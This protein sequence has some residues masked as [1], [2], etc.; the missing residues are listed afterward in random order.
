MSV[1]TVEAILE[2]MGRYPDLAKWDFVHALDVR[3]L[4]DSMHQ[5]YLLRWREGNAIDEINGQFDIEHT[6]LSYNLNDVRLAA[7]QL[8]LSIVSEARP[9]ARVTLQVE[10]TVV[11]LQRL[12]GIRQLAHYDALD[13]LRLRSDHTLVAADGRLQLD[14]PS[15][16]DFFI[17]GMGSS[18]DGTL[19]GVFF[20]RHFAQLSDAQR[21]FLLAGIRPLPDK[22]LRAGKNMVARLQRSDDE[23]RMALVLWSTLDSGANG[24]LPGAPLPF[25]LPDEFAGPQQ[26]T[27]LLSLATLQRVAFAEAILGLIPDG[28][29]SWTRGEG[30]KLEGLSA[31]AGRLHVPGSDY[32]SQA[33]VFQ[34]DGFDLEAQ[35]LR[36]T[37]SAPASEQAWRQSFSLSLKYRP[38]ESS[39]W[40]SLSLTG[41]VTLA[42]RFVLGLASDSAFMT[43]GKLQTSAMGTPVVQLTGGLPPDLPMEARAQIE[44]AVAYSI[45][46]AFYNALAPHL[47]AHI[48][49]QLL[50]DFTVGEAS[51]PVPQRVE[52]A[53]NPA[54]FGSLRAQG[55]TLRIVDAPLVLKARDV[56]TFTVEP[57]DATL[58]WRLTGLPGGSGE[59]GRIDADT[60]TYTAPSLNA[61]GGL[62]TRIMVTATDRVT[63]QTSD[64]LVT[65]LPQGISVNPLIRV[66]QPGDGVQLSAASNGGG[67]LAW[68]IEDAGPGAGHL[69]PT[70]DGAFCTYTAGSPDPE[71]AWV[72]DEIVVSDGRGVSRKVHMLVE[73]RQPLLDIA[74][75]PLQPDGRVQLE[76]RFNGTLLDE[77]TWHLPLGGPGSIDKQGMYAGDPLAVE[78]YVLVA[79]SYQQPEYGTFEG[80]SILPLP[81]S[82]HSALLSQLVWHEANVTG[83]NDPQMTRGHRH[84]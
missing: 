12:R 13:S 2:W 49:E 11:M 69:E 46:K 9:V 81:L 7:P 33:F 29:F 1:H 15:G 40:S 47:T 78:H 34:L 53:I 24:E 65:V 84:A 74:L 64:V 5:G 25:L 21:Y 39:S 72:I 38:R 80:Y 27:S 71:K 4:N 59:W 16:D 17:E 30:G 51:Q 10:G 28:N 3:G 43:E 62:A 18:V 60:G 14:L 20:Q 63:Q 56:H 55:S 42:H 61:M 57:A 79:A 77:V 22:P 48:G 35:T 31:R 32:S 83:S 50:Q 68:S 26:V 6:D 70:P 67:N 45:H 82:A 66:L 54:V 52:S 75:G 23:Q 36:A 8:D 58:H 19:G 41:S 37:F 76:A 73:Q 44:E